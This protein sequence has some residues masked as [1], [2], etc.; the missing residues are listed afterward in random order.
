MRYDGYYANT[1]IYKWLSENEMKLNRSLCDVLNQS[2]PASTDSK[3]QH[4]VSK[5]RIR[6]RDASGR[7]Q[8]YR[9][10]CLQLLQHRRQKKCRARVMWLPRRNQ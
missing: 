4:V 2:V 1:Y 10:V 3:K 9:S 8:P 7:L 5:G 6:H